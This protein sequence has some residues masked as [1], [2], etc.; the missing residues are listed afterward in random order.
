[1]FFQQK[2]VTAFKLLRSQA[3]YGSRDNL[4]PLPS[5]GKYVRFPNV[6]YR[7][8]H[9]QPVVSTTDITA[10]QAVSAIG[11]AD[12]AIKR[13]KIIKIMIFVYR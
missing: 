12:S 7:R 9:G 4:T 13:G 3:T 2:Y 8:K 6:R 10:L 1:M 11:K 5:V